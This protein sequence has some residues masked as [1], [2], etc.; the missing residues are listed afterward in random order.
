MAGKDPGLDQADTM[1][2]F[3]QVRFTQDCRMR[4]YPAFWYRMFRVLQS[5][6]SSALL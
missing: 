3:D 4:S 6:I 1:A 5:Q 2:V